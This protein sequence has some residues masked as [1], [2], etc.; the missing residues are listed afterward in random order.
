MTADHRVIPIRE[1]DRSVGCNHNIGGPK[2]SVGGGHGLF[3]I[4]GGTGPGIFEEVAIDHAL[5]SLGMQQLAPVFLRQQFSLVRYDAARRSC[6]E[7][8]D[9]RHHARKFVVEMGA[10][11]FLPAPPAGAPIAVAAAL[12]NVIQAGPGVAVI[13]VVALPYAAERI[14]R[15]LVRVAKIVAQDRQLRAVW[16]HA[17]RAA[18]IVGAG[19]CAHQVIAGLIG[20]VEAGIAVVQVIASIGTEHYLVHAMIVIYAA[21]PG[22]QNF[23]LDNA[24]LIVLGVYDDVGRLRDDHFVS[25]DGNS[26]RGAQ[27]GV[28]VEDF[29]FIGLSVAMGI[30]ED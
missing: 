14:D 19:P 18:G 21:P 29:N 20:D 5:A 4:L 8:R 25:Q 7:P 12:E 22:Q 24:V 2:P 6:A 10:F 16:I 13:V 1:E 3:G 15:Q 17:Q 23:F 26:Q 27:R 9:I 11:V 28:L 30:F